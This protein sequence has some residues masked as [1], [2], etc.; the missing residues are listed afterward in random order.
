LEAG[1][2]QFDRAIPAIRPATRA[3]CTTVPRRFMPTQFARHIAIAVLV[4]GSACAHLR[5]ASASHSD[6]NIITK[7]QLTNN[8]F[9]TVYDAVESLRGNWLQTRGT[10]SFQSPSQVRVYLDN[11]LFGNVESM[12][13]IATTTISFVRWFDGVSAT[14]RWGLD[15]GAGVIYISSRPAIATDPE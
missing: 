1:N 6:R 14:A 5:A 8:H 3:H 15:H 9:S 12:R 7:E 10:D 4:L 2:S 11:T 13:S